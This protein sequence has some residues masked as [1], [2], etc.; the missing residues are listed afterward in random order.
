MLITKHG[1]TLLFICDACECQF[2]VGIHSVKT[3]D[4]GE[5]YYCNCPECG[6][7]CHTD[8]ARQELQNPRY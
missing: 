5:N 8:V 6:C 2:F 4:N 1:K 7:E 3:P